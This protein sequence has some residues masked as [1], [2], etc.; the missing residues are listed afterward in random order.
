MCR[1]IHFPII[2]IGILHCYIARKVIR[3][4]HSYFECIVSANVKS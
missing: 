3:I 1:T 2:R 4:G